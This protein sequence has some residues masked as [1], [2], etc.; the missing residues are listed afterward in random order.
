[1]RRRA[2]LQ[3]L[4]GSDPMLLEVQLQDLLL[5]PSSQLEPPNLCDLFA[6]GELDE[7]PKA[8]RSRVGSFLDRARAE[9]AEIAD[10]AEMKTFADEI[11]A[12]APARVPTSL[13]TYLAELA[14]RESRDGAPLERLLEGLE[15][16]EPEPF[17][18]GQPTIRV[19]RAEAVKPESTRSSRRSSGN[20]R[21]T[22][23][24]KSAPKTTRAAPV[25]D[26][27]RQKWIRDNVIEML[28]GVSENGLNQPV[29]IAGIRH[30]AKPHYPR[31][32]PHEVMAV[33][34]DLL[35]KGLVRKSASRWSRA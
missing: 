19:Q 5:R 22:A 10:G 21:S 34:N 23:A 29:V 8:V 24:R 1:M 13:R 14:S 7:A 18:L 31:L 4:R 6:L 27:E 32:G 35:K 16:T 15:G 11:A 26:V 9:L 17:T 28:S 25:V 2:P 20:A 30:R 3:N 12:V 33:L